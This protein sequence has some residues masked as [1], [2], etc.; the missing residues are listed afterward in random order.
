MMRCAGAER[1]RRTERS[2][3]VTMASLPVVL[4]NSASWAVMVRSWKYPTSAGRELLSGSNRCAPADVTLV[5][6]DHD[7]L[8]RIAHGAA[9]KRAVPVDGHLAARA[10]SRRA[11][12]SD[13]RLAGAGPEGDRRD[14]RGI[15][16]AALLVAEAGRHRAVHGE[17]GG[18]GVVGTHGQA[19]HRRPGMPGS[20]PAGRP[21]ARNRYCRPR[22]LIRGSDQPERVWAEVVLFGDATPCHRPRGQHGAVEG[23]PDAGQRRDGADRDGDRPRLQRWMPGCAR[24]SRARPGRMAQGRRSP[25]R[26]LPARPPRPAGHLICR[27]DPLGRSRLAFTARRCAAAWAA[28]RRRAAAATLPRRRSRRAGRSLLPEAAGGLT[29]GEAVR[30]RRTGR[31]G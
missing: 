8:H 25:G 4:P 7:A 21:S 22:R 6:C 16:R 24:V 1:Q 20:G 28:R 9:G 18:H 12:L 19:P 30:Q 14:T 27:L 23:E 15:E 11:G 10:R 3:M 17:R 2:G 31:P 13:C 29:A 26:P 5:P